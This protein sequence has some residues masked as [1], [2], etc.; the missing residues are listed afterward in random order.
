MRSAFSAVQRIG[1]PTSARQSSPLAEIQEDHIV[2]ETPTLLD[3]R[4][5]AA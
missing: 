1:V 4:T 5:H 3:E 2:G